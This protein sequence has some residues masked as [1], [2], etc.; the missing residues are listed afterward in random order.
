MAARPQIIRLARLAGEAASGGRAPPFLHRSKSVLI[1]GLPSSTSHACTHTEH[2]A[3]PQTL[4]L[5]CGLQLQAPALK[6]S[7]KRVRVCW[8]EQGESPGHSTLARTRSRSSMVFQSLQVF[9]PLTLRVV[10]CYLPQKQTHSR[11]TTLYS[12]WKNSTIQL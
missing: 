9:F 3:A 11:H 1:R 8:A 5:H 4:Y 12:L 7:K 2:S 10:L 6:G